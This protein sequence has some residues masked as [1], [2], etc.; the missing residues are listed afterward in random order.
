VPNDPV[1][2]PEGLSCPVR[3]RFSDREKLRMLDGRRPLHPTRGVGILLRRKGC[4]L[5]ALGHLAPI[6]TE[7]IAA[8]P[9]SASLRAG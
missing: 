1:T 7:A 9:P 2:Q 6:A 8:G 4:L 5:L 3:R